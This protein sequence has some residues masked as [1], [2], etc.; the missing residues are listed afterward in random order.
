MNDWLFLLV[1]ILFPTPKFAYDFD[2]DLERENFL[3]FVVQA[4]AIHAFESFINKGMF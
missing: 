1:Q 4:K 2:K 3:S